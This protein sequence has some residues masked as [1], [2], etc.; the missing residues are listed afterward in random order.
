MPNPSFQKVFYGL[1]KGGLILAAVSLGAPWVQSQLLPEWV[2]HGASQA[3]LWAT[4]A[5]LGSAGLNLLAIGWAKARSRNAPWGSARRMAA[6][7]AVL[8]VRA[9][10]PFFDLTQQQLDGA[11][12]DSERAAVEM[13]E[14]MNDIHRISHLQFEHIQVTQSHSQKLTQVIHDKLMADTQLSSILQ[15]FVQ[16]QEEDVAANLERIKRLQGVK[17]LQP[18]VDMIAVVARQTNFLAI[19]AAIEAARAGE[20][21][22]GFAVVAAEIRHLSI[23]TAE[24]AVDIATKINV[25]TAGIDREL[26][27]S[28]DTAH[29]GNS[30]GNLRRVLA[31]IDE[32]QQR[33]ANSMAEMELQRVIDEVKTGHQDIAGRLGDALALVQ[34]QDVM[35][36]RVEQTQQALADMKLHLEQVAD[37]LQDKPWDPDAM[38]ELRQRL[39]SQA[40]RYVMESQRITHQ[41]VIGSAVASSRELPKVELF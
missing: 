41:K 6:P 33:F 7:Q 9:A 8:E 1:A 40:D 4:V 18:L 16:K 36:Q 26:T 28:T 34:G 11:V 37:Q 3:A 39:Q 21:G 23:R 31:D 27:S 20:A 25:A 14:R 13:I 10:T 12:K 19:N 22:R 24:V 35:R 2:I 15:M 29:R 32:M 17:D 5:L 38:T 30:T